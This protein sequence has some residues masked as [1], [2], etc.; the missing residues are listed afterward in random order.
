MGYVKVRSRP[1]L[2]SGLISGALLILGGV[3]WAGGNLLGQWLALIVTLVLIIVFID[4]L[5]KTRKFMPAGLMII[6]GI[7]ALIAMVMSS[8]QLP[9]T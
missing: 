7:I 6:A 1:S 2:I 3:L 9:S 4:R 5:R 8:L